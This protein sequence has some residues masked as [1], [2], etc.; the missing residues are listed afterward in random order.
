LRDV[1][2]VTSNDLQSQKVFINGKEAIF[3]AN[4]NPPDITDYAKKE[5]N[6]NWPVEIAPHSYSFLHFY[7][8]AKEIGDIEIV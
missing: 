5:S 1:Y 2:H 3:P 4:G 7:G 8:M 6:K